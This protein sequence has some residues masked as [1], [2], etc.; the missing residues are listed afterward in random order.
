[1]KTKI[2]FMLLLCSFMEMKSQ[3]L[4]TMPKVQRDS[5]LIEI[6]KN[7]IKEFEPNYYEMYWVRKPSSQ[8]VIIEEKRITEDNFDPKSFFYGVKSGDVWYSVIFPYENW[9]EAKFD[10]DFLA[11]VFILNKDSRPVLYGLG[12]SGMYCNLR[13]TK[14]PLKDQ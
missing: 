10:E 13:L 11:K 2:I 7:T 4:S 14:K 1:M 9:R 12:I 6:A 3:E 8:S 5:V